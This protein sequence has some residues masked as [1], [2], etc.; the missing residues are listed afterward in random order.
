MCTLTR[1][2]YAKFNVYKGK[3]ALQLSLI[4]PT[5][6]DTAKGGVYVDREGVLFMEFA[7]TNATAQQQQGYGNRSYNWDQKLVFAMKPTE[8]GHFLDDGLIAKGFDLFHDP[9][10]G[11]AVSTEQYL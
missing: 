11:G 2:V 1:Q 9:D 3:G 4:P 6:K 10:K 8:L 7:A 5:W